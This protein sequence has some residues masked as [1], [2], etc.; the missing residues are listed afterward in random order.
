MKVH[1][2]AVKRELSKKIQPQLKSAQHGFRD[3][4]SVV[5]NLLCLVSVYASTQSI[6]TELPIGYILWRLQGSIRQTGDHVVDYQTGQIRNWQENGKMVMAILDWQNQFCS[7]WE[8]QVQ[9]VRITIWGTSWKLI[10]T[11]DVHCF[12]R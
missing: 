8:V 10:G 4:R 3:K 9:T 11:V 2:V 1:D 7:D 6:R 12:H 5:T